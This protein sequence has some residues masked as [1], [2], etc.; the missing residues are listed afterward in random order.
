MEMNAWENISVPILRKTPK[1][2]LFWSRSHVQQVLLSANCYAFLECHPKKSVRRNIYLFI[3]LNEIIFWII[4][5]SK[6]TQILLDSG[7]AWEVP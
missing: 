4:S 2:A 7:C 1:S 6:S 3:V 5:L